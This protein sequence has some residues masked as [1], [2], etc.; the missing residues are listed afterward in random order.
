MDLGKVVHPLIPALRRQEARESLKWRLAKSTE[1]SRTAR[2]MQSNGTLS[3]R[4]KKKKRK[5]KRAHS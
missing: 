1:R 5:E 2:A 4:N 3:Q